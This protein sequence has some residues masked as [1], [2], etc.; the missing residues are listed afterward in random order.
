VHLFSG[1]TYCGC[2]E[3]MYVP[4]NS[5]KYVCWSCRNKIPVTDLEAIFYEQLKNFFLSPADIAE[6]LKTADQNLAKKEELLNVLRTEQDKVKQ[7]IERVYRLYQ[8]SQLSSEGFGRFYKPLEERHRQLEDEIP[9][10]QAEVDFLKINHLSSD[11]IRAEA[12]DLY[13]RWP[14][15]TREEKQRI[16]ES[17]TDKIVVAEDGIEISLCYLPSSE[18]LVKE[19]RSL[20]DSSQQRA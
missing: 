13:G 17:V 11:R 19:Q 2:G 12:K 5:P 3:K 20:W 4:S 16:V 15:L 7:E 8:E 14:S 6:H 9:T 18:E 1:I 10:A